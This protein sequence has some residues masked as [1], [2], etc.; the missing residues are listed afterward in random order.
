MTKT[1]ASICRLMLRKWALSLAA[2][3]PVEAEFSQGR[4]PLQ[5]NRNLILLNALR[6]NVQ[7]F[8]SKQLPP[9]HQI[10]TSGNGHHR[11][12]V[13]GIP[14]CLLDC[15]DQVVH[16]LDHWPR[17]AVHVHA[18]GVKELPTCVPAWHHRAEHRCGK[19]V[20]GEI[21]QPKIVAH[22]VHE[23][24]G[25]GDARRHRDEGRLVEEQVVRV[26]HY[27]EAG[28]GDG[29][30]AEAELGRHIN[31]AIGFGQAAAKRGH[32]VSYLLNEAFKGEAVRPLPAVFT[33]RTDTS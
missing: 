29:D 16:R 24:V 27:L 3:V 6:A 7:W 21:Q 28:L 26:V 30:L 13:T 2:P 9:N 12:P 31:A 8:F 1:E 11:F 25:P 23:V 33:Q 5:R 22:G 10:N 15:A 17:R 19:D 32:K 18:D 4:P 14:F 20:R